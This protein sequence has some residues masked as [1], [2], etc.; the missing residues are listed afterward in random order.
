MRLCL[1]CLARMYFY[2]YNLIS[3][4]AVGSSSG[5]V[6]S[7]WRRRGTG[8]LMGT[9][10]G[11][12]A[13]PSLGKWGQE[14]SGHGDPWLDRRSTAGR[15]DSRAMHAMVQGVLTHACTHT[16][17]K[18]THMHTHMHEHTY[19]AVSNP[20]HTNKL[21]YTHANK[22]IHTHYC[23]Q[24]IKKKK[25]IA[26]FAVIYLDESLFSSWDWSL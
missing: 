18:S 7:W 22:L 20:M 10:W 9:G 25:L 21:T 23:C 4:L 15:A 13:W 14:G 5:W 11:L 6:E 16:P 24:S 19:G 26:Q 1:R 2:Y 17:P 12:G 8:L 3:A